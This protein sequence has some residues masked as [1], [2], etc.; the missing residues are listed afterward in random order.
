[1]IKGC[2]CW[3]SDLVNVEFIYP[4]EEILTLGTGAYP[5]GFWSKLLCLKHLSIEL[6]YMIL[7]FIVKDRLYRLNK[8]NIKLACKR[9]TTFK[10][11]SKLSRVLK[12][13]KYINYTELWSRMSFHVQIPLVVLRWTKLSATQ[14]IKAP[15]YVWYGYHNWIMFFDIII[16][17]FLLC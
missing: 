4:Y 16:Q 3:K 17:N 2:L 9:T 8:R 10:R 7:L 15:A 13:L 5:V 12:N 6:K 11:K 1:M 14:L